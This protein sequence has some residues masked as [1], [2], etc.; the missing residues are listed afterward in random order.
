MFKAVSKKLA[1]DQFTKAYSFNHWTRQVAAGICSYMDYKLSNL[2][3][4]MIGPWVVAFNYRTTELS[5][6][7]AILTKRIFKI[8]TIPK[9]LLFNM[10]QI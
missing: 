10:I 1:S 2:Y 9:N 6:K 5:V 7:L 4:H 8:P 3:L